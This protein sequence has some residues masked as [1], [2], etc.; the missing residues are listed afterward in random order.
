MSIEFVMSIE[1]P[2]AAKLLLVSPGVQL[3]RPL[4][5]DGRTI[6]FVDQSVAIGHL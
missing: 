3:A 1:K 6:G 5:A 4:A 2:S